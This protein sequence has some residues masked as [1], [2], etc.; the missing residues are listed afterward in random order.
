MLYQEDFVFTSIVAIGIAMAFDWVTFATYGIVAL[1]IWLVLFKPPFNTKYYQLP[2]KAPYGYL[3]TLQSLSTNDNLC[4]FPRTHQK[5]QSS[6]CRINLKVR[7]CP[8]TIS[9]AVADIVRD[10]LMDPTTVK[11]EGL[12][13]T[14]KLFTMNGSRSCHGRTAMS[15]AFENN[16]VARMNEITIKKTDQW[17]HRR[18]DMLAQKEESI[19]INQEMNDLTLS[20]LLRGSL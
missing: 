10:I 19:D 11:P 16:Q 6:I 2:P 9:V 1:M 20:I 13:K 4:F 5:V 18:L 14:L 12:P 3:Q 17:I 7:G 8:Y 15:Q